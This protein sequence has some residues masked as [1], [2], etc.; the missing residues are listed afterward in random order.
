MKNKGKSS[1]ENLERPCRIPD[2][3]LTE[4]A[5]PCWPLAKS[6]KKFYS[7]KEIS[8]MYGISLW[9]LYEHVKCDP[10]FPVINIGL[11]NVL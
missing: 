10:T 9:L 3:P 7:I 6:E 8:N 2:Q 5:D 11:K 1:L 4:R